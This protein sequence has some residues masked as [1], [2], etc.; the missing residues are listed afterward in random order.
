MRTTLNRLTLVIMFGVATAGCATN[1]ALPPPLIQATSAEGL[2]VTPVHVMPAGTP[3][4]PTPAGYVSFCL[5]F[6]D[7][8]AAPAPGASATITLTPALWGTLGQVNASVNEDIL[9]MDDQTHFGRAEYW[10]IPTD[11]YGNCHDYALTKRKQLI[12]AG[13]PQAALRISIVITPRNE[14]HAILTAVTDRGDYVLDNLTDEIRPWDATGYVWIERQD[15][16]RQFGWVS[17]QPV[18]RMMAD[19]GALKVT[20][21]TQ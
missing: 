1:G 3:D 13:L 2:T 19:S 4:A 5:R 20:G 14:R 12:D 11:G 21:T 18:E 16:N 10:T 6:A 17:L 15:P 7:Q 8:C 9:P